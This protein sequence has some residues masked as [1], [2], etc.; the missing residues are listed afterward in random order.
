MGMARKWRGVVGRLKI[1]RGV[2][3]RHLSPKLII[4]NSTLM[5]ES[6][7]VCRTL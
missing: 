2:F 5:D 4:H 3:E 1:V 7:D 6:Q